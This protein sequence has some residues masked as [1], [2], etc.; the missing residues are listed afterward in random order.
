MAATLPAMERITLKNG[1]EVVAIPLHNDTGVVSVNVYYRVGSRNETMG[2]SGLAHMLEHMSFKSTKNLKAGEYDRIVKG[3]GGITNASTGFDFTH[4]FIKSA[5]PNIDKSLELFAELMSGLSLKDEEFQPERNVVAEERRWRTDNS[6][7][8]SMYFSLFNNAFHHHPY[9]WTP[10][11]FMGD[12][13]GWS[14]DDVRQFYRSWYQPQNAILLVAG[15]FEPKEL[16]S[17]AK[18]RFEG[19][20]NSGDLPKITASEPQQTGARRATLIKESEVEMLIISWK[21]PPFDSADIVPLNALSSLLTN[22]ASSRLQEKLVDELQL[23]NFVS[24]YP[25]DAKDTGLFV[26]IAACNTGVKAE[27]VEKVILDEIAAIG[28]KAP[29][30]KEVEKVKTMTKAEF[31]YSLESSDHIAGLFGDMLARGNIEPLLGYEAAVNALEAKAIQNSV[32]SYLKSEFSTT[33]ILRK[34]D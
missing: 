1:L 27:A 20:K 11:G 7:I 8:G 9:H 3:F 24:A 14:I 25:M 31:I 29:S 19:L 28:K 32:R 10:I 13:E 30:T 2:K 15:D 23:V 16:F 33:I 12:I 6:P 26:I 4:Y 18:K 17:L 22:G 5:T 21:I 34:A